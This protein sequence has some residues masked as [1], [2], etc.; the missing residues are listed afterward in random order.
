MTFKDYGVSSPQEFFTELNKKA[1][2]IALNTNDQQTRKDE[3]CIS[4][5]LFG[6][7]TW[8]KDIGE[9]LERLIQKDMSFTEVTTKFFQKLTND[10]HMKSLHKNITNGSSLAKGPKQCYYCVKH[11]LPGADTHLNKD[12]VKK[13]EYIKKKY[14]DEAKFSTSKSSGEKRPFKSVQEGAAGPSTPSY[15]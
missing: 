5:F 14:G 3:T 10:T 6:I 7:K 4:A 11:N 2:E 15:R 13:E 1:L 9:Q 12:C 8:D